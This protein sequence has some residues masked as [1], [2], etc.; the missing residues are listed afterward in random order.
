MRLAGEVE[1]KIVELRGGRISSRSDG[2]ARDST[3]AMVGVALGEHSNIKV[4]HAL[5]KA[6]P[7]P[8]SGGSRLGGPA[9]QGRESIDPRPKDAKIDTW[10]AFPAIQRPRQAVSIVL[11]EWTHKPL[12]LLESDSR[13][14]VGF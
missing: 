8:E 10:R 4:L 6:G 14:I 13:L 12:I 1:S 2:W 11:V 7:R 3:R 9:I 5:R